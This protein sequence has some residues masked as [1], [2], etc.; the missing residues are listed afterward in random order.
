MDSR[1]QIDQLQPSA[2]RT[3]VLS[4]PMNSCQSA[5]LLNRFLERTHGA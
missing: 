2:Y 4:F 1:T 5:L 3:S